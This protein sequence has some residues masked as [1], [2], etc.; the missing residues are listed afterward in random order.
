LTEVIVETKDEADRVLRAAQGGERLEALATRYSLRRRMEPVNGHAVGEGGKM[1][2]DTLISSPYREF[3]GDNNTE[4]VGKLQGPL[5]VQERY[6][7]FRLDK[8][9]AL[10]PFTFAQARVRVIRRLRN[11]REA[12]R[13]GAFMDSLRSA[14]A[15]QIT[16]HTKRIEQ[17]AEQTAKPK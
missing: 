16:W 3:F 17:Y 14:E 15:E 2:I 5:K 8:P 4:A 6:S 11:E 13:F 9:V 10:I 1:R 12:A 7:V